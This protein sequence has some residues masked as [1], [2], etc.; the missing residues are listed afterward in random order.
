MQMS[1]Q[2]YPQGPIVGSRS[3]TL[4]LHTRMVSVSAPS[5]LKNSRGSRIDT[6]KRENNKQE[7]KD[8]NLAFK[9]GMV[10]ATS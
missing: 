10:A 5:I 7:T 3:D 8:C 2:D 9:A 6:G 1:R 4:S